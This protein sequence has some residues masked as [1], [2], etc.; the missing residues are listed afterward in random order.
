MKKDTYRDAV[1]VVMEETSCPIYEV[2]DELK[3]QNFSLVTS[4]YKASCLH[5]AQKIA[6]IVTIKKNFSTSSPK[7]A[8]QKLQFDCGGCGASKIFFD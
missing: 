2:G 5:L 1:F 6:D 7:A 8:G 3:V 4:N